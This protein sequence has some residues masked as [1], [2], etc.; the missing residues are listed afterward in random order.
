[1]TEITPSGNRFSDWHD[2]ELI[3]QHRS[4]IHH[5]LLLQLE[6]DTGDHV[7]PTTHRAVWCVPSQDADRFCK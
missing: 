4:L 3:D 6:V 7:L 5:C 1:M 2:C